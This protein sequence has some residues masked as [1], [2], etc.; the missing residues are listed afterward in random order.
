MKNEII[1]REDFTVK[2]KPRELKTYVEYHKNTIYSD[3]K[4]R[5]IAR[6]AKDPYKTFREELMPFSYFCSLLYGDRQDVCCYLAS[7]TPGYD[8]I[9]EDGE[10]KHFVE[11]TWPID[12]NKHPKITKALNKRGFYDDKKIYNYND[13]SIVLPVFDDIIDVAEKKSLKDYRDGSGSTLLFVYEDNILWGDIPNRLES[14]RRLI[15]R[16]SQITYKVNNVCLL[17]LFDGTYLLYYVKK[18]HKMNDS[19]ENS[20]E[21]NPEWDESLISKTGDMVFLKITDS[22]SYKIQCCVIN[23]DNNI[24]SAEITGVFDW[25]DLKQV[26]DSIDF[27]GDIIDITKIIG[28]TVSVSYNNIFEVIPQ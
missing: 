27:Q 4:I 7:G 10:N 28:Q 1:D 22:F 3:K 19:F 24:V 18:E 6:I 13:D 17:V 26:G 11:I 20:F 15:S 21:I 25:D 2:R 23:I 14:H 9:I 16:L 12:S 5:R 8:A